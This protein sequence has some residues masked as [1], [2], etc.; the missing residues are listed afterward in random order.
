MRN[1]FQG[2]LM[3]FGLASALAVAKDSPSVWIRELALCDPGCGPA[4]VAIDH[5]DAVWVALA[6]AGKLARYRD[7]A[8]EM[9][10]LGADSRPVGI[11]VTREALWIAASYDNKIIRFDLATQ[12]V[13]SYAIEVENSWPFF[14]AIGN[15]GAVWFSQRAASKIGRLDPTTGT[16]KYF[17]TPTPNSGPAG[18]AVDKRTGRLWFTQSYA[19]RIASLDP[20]SGVITEYP[21]GEASTGLV[22]GPAG[23]TV[24]AQ[25]GVWFAKLEGKLGHLAPDSK[26]IKIVDTPADARRPAGV[27]LDGRG[28]VWL[29]ALDGN[30]LLRYQP[31]KGQFV[32]YPLPTGQPDLTPSNPPAARSAR[33]FGIAADRQGNIWFSEQYTGQLGVIDAAAPTV[34]ILSPR[35]VVSER[36]ILLTSR[37]LDRVSGV[38][39][40]LWSIDDKAV[41][42][43]NGRLDISMLQP[44]PHTLLA[45]V[46]DHAGFKSEAKLEFT[47]KPPAGTVAVRILDSAPYFEPAVVEVKAGD[48]VEWKYTPTPDAHRAAHN[49]RRVTIESLGITSSALRAG[50]SFTYR[51]ERPGTFKVHTA[52]D[53]TA[54]DSGLVKVSAR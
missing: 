49:L 8:V 41:K 20:D 10:D 7:G 46:T 13:R 38:R 5:T 30:S 16:F 4:I 52:V 54:T 37:A 11:A 9:F 40:T 23:I 3:A 48:T 47:L 15:D 12:A 17:D 2:L 33:P 34:E 45:S 29:V 14:V 1:L 27:A 31:D 21:M 19:D 18:V 25:G 26:E 53:E 24:D 39:E 22:S 44:G 28:S 32:S 6:R 43:V 51:F 50:D 35:A 42:P 36:S